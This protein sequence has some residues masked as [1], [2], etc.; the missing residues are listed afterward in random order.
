MGMGQ[1]LGHPSTTGTRAPSATRQM[2]DFAANTLSSV[3]PATFSITSIFS[4]TS[5]TGRMSRTLKD[6][7][8]DTAIGDIVYTRRLTLVNVYAG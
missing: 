4:H 1:N 2:S 7:K 6:P 3:S 8:R 5:N